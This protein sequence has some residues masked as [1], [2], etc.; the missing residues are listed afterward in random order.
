MAIV[1]ALLG[2]KGLFAG[3]LGALSLRKQMLIII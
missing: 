3:V 1:R 2:R